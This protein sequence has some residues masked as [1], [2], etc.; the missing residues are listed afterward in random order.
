MIKLKEPDYDLPK[1]EKD[2]MDNLFSGRSSTVIDGDYH[3]HVEDA[4][5]LHRATLKHDHR[6]FLRK[7][8][9]LKLLVKPILIFIGLIILAVII[10]NRSTAAESINYAVFGIFIPFGIISLIIYAWLIKKPSP[11]KLALQ[12]EIEGFKM[13]LEMAEKDRLRLLNPPER[14]PEHFEAMLPYAF[15]LGVEHQW[16]ENF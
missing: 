11:E 3:P 13:Y 5:T 1:E 12:S 10:M 8:D 2:I 15:A 14:T 9:N 7:G 4:Y 16:T 6:N